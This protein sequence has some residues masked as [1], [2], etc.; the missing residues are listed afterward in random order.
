[1]VRSVRPVSSTVTDQV[2]QGK[3]VTAA[4]TPEAVEVKPVTAAM[5]QD[6]GSINLATVLPFAA[7]AVALPFILRGKR[8]KR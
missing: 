6:E 1:M 4:M 2:Q 8:K 5:T 7:V 3:S